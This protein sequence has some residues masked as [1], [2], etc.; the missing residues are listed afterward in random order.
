M[1]SCPESHRQTRWITKGLE[2]LAREL[3]ASQ[4][5][6][7]QQEAGR[8][9]GETEDPAFDFD[10]LIVGS[11]Y[12]GSVAAAELTNGQGR[13]LSVCVLE[14]GREY[15][16]GMFPDRFSDLPGF[17]RFATPDAKKPRGRLD[18]LFDF[19]VGGDVNVLVASGVG[20][21]SLI[22]AGVMELP[23]ESVFEE[24]RWPAAIR[25]DARRLRRFGAV[26]QKRLGASPRRTPMQKA[27]TL[28]ALAAGAPTG[29]SYGLVHVTVAN[30]DGPNGAGTQLTAC[31]GCGDC[32]TGCN[33]NAKDSLDLNLLR[34]AQKRGARIFTGATVLRLAKVEK[35]GGWIVYVNHTEEHLRMRQADPFE[36]RAHVVILCAGTMGSTEIL[37]RSEA[38]GLPFS[39]QLGK[40]FSANGDVIATIRDVVDQGGD[41]KAV[42]DPSVAPDARKIGPTIGGM[43]DLRNGDPQTDLVIQDLAV[44]SALHRIFLETV[45]CATMLQGLVA[46]DKKRQFPDEARMDPAAVR[47]DTAKTAMAVAMIVR[48]AADGVLRRPMQGAWDRADGLVTVRWPELRNDPRFVECH[49]SLQAFASA[50][51]AGR[52]AQPPWVIANPVWRPLSADLEYVFGSQ[53]GPLLSVHPLGGCPMG[54][55]EAT[56][57]VDH[58]GRVFDPSSA[59]GVVHEGLYVLDGSIVPTS[60]GINPALTIATLA[61]RAVRGIAAHLNWRKCSGLQPSG[62]RLSDRPVF[63]LQ[64][65]RH[66]V[67]T[68]IELT[69]ELRGT[70]H[71][72]GE[73]AGCQGHEARL[74]L[75]Y[76]AKPLADLCAGDWK[77]R[78]LKVGQGRLRILDAAHTSVIEAEVTGCLRVFRREKSRYWTR[79]LRALWA[80]FLNRG[81][82]DIGQRL[83]Q[84]CSGWLGVAEKTPLIIGRYLRDI[85]R[86]SDH[87]GAVRLLEYDLEV[88]SAVSPNNSVDPKAFHGALTGVKRLAYTHAANPWR[89]L[90]TI[91]V[92]RFPKL[93]RW[94]ER[95]SGAIRLASQRRWREAW[96][97]WRDKPTL[98]LNVKYLAKEEVPL[99][100]VVRQEDRPAALA[101]LMTFALYA[102]RAILDI[103]ILSFRKP[104]V[105]LPRTP[106]RLPREIRCGA[107]DIA[108]EIEWLVVGEGPDTKR[109]VRARLARYRTAAC[110]R[111]ANPVLLIHGYSASGTTFAHPAVQGNLAEVL[112]QAGRDVWIVDMRSSSGMPTARDG[113]AFEDM[114]EEDIPKVIARV[115]QTCASQKVDV[116]AHCMGSAM[117]NMALLGDRN[118]SLSERIGRLVLSQVGPVMQMSAANVFRGYVMRWAR[119]FLP[120]TDYSFR[121]PPEKPGLG[122]QVIDRVLATTPYPPEEFPLEN[123]L[124]PIGKATPW[125]SLRHRMDA[126]YA[127]T[128]KLANMPPRVLE[129]ID[130]FFGP[131]SVDTVSQVIHFAR[132]KTITDRTGRNVYVTPFRIGS[133]MRFPVLYIHGE[134]NGLV[135]VESVDLMRNAWLSSGLPWLGHDGD[136]FRSADDVRE[137][138]RN[139]EAAR[140]NGSLVT[141]CI[142]DHGHQDPLI[143]SGAKQVSTVIE[144]FLR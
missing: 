120:L 13:A 26:M 104:D 38:K 34:D 49:R 121:P 144:E 94:W 115:L 19:R 119:Q 130:D 109:A 82:R 92:R 50:A 14:R 63:A 69:E 61:V 41:A 15:L 103:H 44:P 21:G 98:C 87:S 126:L 95:L 28:K 6:R 45:S 84:T 129:C 89:Q 68:Q 16:R 70:V 118:G 99:L 36:V 93:E 108:P 65:A 96:S 18:G 127:R 71:L 51:A 48:D 10:V 107:V 137:A 97:R 62:E 47:D 7:A 11:G 54:D 37:M 40:K 90:T 102:L 110:E 5:R 23:L 138:I 114:A 32:A 123:P 134:E 86:L 73:A 17:V 53:R 20:G 91:E 78:E 136:H 116:V 100:R 139:R 83:F 128:F 25:S 74:R 3:H 75:T 46:T 58:L 66:P 52:R 39:A 79:K 85:W 60:L 80:W 142:R 55:D 125:A 35:G 57:V 9:D 105:A 43:I 27:Q 117:L 31:N 4:A 30:S 131:L 33:F 29:A 101:D 113:W 140:A 106:S 2:S 81:L 56:G 12:G 76:D 112:C 64:R 59:N 133:R 8:S 77:K 135:D 24:P 124:W 72:A 42:A 141:W 111:G 122:A 143:G 22:N 1:P 132:T 67:P 88:C